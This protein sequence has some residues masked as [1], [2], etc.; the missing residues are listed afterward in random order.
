[1]TKLVA[2]LVL[3]RK[4]CHQ[5]SRAM[6]LGRLAFGTLGVSRGT[7]YG[8]ALRTVLRGDTTTGDG[9]TIGSS[10]DWS[11]SRF[12]LNFWPQASTYVLDPQ[13]ARKYVQPIRAGQPMCGGR[14]G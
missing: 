4:T 12:D 6:S 3:Y 5:R 1:M 14:E 7:S 10:K 2:T 9:A 11:S 8:E 13:D